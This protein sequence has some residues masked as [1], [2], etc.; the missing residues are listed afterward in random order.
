MRATKGQ[1][2]DACEQVRVA[3]RRKYLSPGHW[4][5][6]GCMRFGGEPEKRCM[7]TEDGWDG[8]AL[9][10]HWLESAPRPATPGRV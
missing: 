6:W 7:R 5:C 9:A 10:N 4:Q 1:A 3:N 8:C 2:L